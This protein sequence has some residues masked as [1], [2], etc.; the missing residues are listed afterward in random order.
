MKNSHKILPQNLHMWHIFCTFA[1]D[2]DFDL[3]AYANI[4]T[5]S[6]VLL[7]AGDGGADLYFGHRCRSRR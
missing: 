4:P 6:V 1:A 3:Y 7:P 2:L 5:N